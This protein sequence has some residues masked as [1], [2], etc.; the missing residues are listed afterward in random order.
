MPILA[1]LIMAVYFVQISN[2][3][4]AQLAC[5]TMCAHAEGPSACFG[6][7]YVL[8]VARLLQILSC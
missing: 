1:I 8:V 7:V 3:S 5:L 2:S 6:E 4:D